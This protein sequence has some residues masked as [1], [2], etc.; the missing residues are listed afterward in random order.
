MDPIEPVNGC[1]IM[2][3]S[4][5]EGISSGYTHLNE[6]TVVCS[7]NWYKNVYKSVKTGVKN[8]VIHSV[9]PKHILD[10]DRLHG[11]LMARLDKVIT[12]SVL[13]PKALWPLNVQKY[14]YCFFHR[15]EGSS[16]CF[17]TGAF[18]S[19]CLWSRLKS[20][21]AWGRGFVIGQFI[22]HHLRGRRNSI[23]GQKSVRPTF[24]FFTLAVDRQ[25]EWRL[26]S[27]CLC[28]PVI[29]GSPLWSRSPLQSPL[30]HQSPTSPLR[31][32]SRPL[33]RWAPPALR[34]DKKKIS[35]DSIESYSELNV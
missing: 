10:N 26:S 11:Q 24:F 1:L 16:A 7:L 4:R 8:K 9:T 22:L 17:H 13:A 23:H 3:I 29:W 2:K 27:S 30:P 12:V 6:G 18:C 21:H 19:L 28:L 35:S 20:L 5:N 32:R 33:S 31:L 34:P 15:D 25:P 14:F